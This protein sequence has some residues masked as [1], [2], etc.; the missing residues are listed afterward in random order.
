MST[1]LVL[2]EYVDQ[3]LDGVAP[4]VWD[5]VDQERGHGDAQ[6]RLD[7]FGSSVRQEQVQNTFS[8]LFKLKGKRYFGL[9]LCIKICHTIN[10][11]VNECKGKQG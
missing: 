3:V 7:D 9:E 1:F 2:L 4:L 10:G 6:P 5:A 8:E 11:Q